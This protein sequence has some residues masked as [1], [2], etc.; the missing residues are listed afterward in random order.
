MK[1][2]L[3]LLLITAAINGYA[4][5]NNTSSKPNI[6]LILAD[7]LGY[8]DI[9]A[10]GSE[11]KTPNLDRL[12]T[13]GLR[14]KEF[15]N[16]SICAP[17]RASLLTGQYQHK[18]G[19]GYFANDLGSPAYQGYL[20]KESLTLAEV[21][22]GAGYTTLMAGK[23]HVSGKGQSL[24][25]QRG[26]DHSLLS[27]NGSYFDQGD[28]NGGP[29]RPY[30]EDGKPY[31]LEAG[32]YY[33]TDVIT[34]H[35]V[36]YLNEQGK[37]KKPFFLYLAYTAPHWPLQALPEDIAKYKGRYDKGWD[38]LR[39]ERFAKQKELGIVD[40]DAVLSAKD[41]DIYDWSRLSYDQ[42]SQWTAKMEVFA[43]MVDR[44]DQG[45][46]Q[47]LDKLKQTGQDKN[48]LVIFIS[49]NGAPAEDLVKWHNGATRNTGP[50]GTIGSYESQGKNWSYASNTPFLAF[51]DYV[52][53]GGISSPFIAWYPSKIKPGTISKGTGHLIDLAPT[54]YEL[55]G[56][57]YPKK[58]KDIVPNALPGKSLL[59]VLYGQDN[60]VKRGEPLFWER[61]GNR[62]V[63][64]GKWKLESHYPSYT[65][66]LYDVESDRGETRDIARFNHDVVSRLSIAYFQWAKKVGS[67]DFSTIEDREPQTMK[68][69]RKSKVQ[70]V[71]APGG[72]GLQ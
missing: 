71:I 44:M 7:D 70:D 39:K 67:V 69:Y 40:K 66:E 64:D 43:A 48:T 30:F 6:I 31:P 19:V 50:V 38:D 51:K 52:Y 36:K 8:S 45:I 46:G 24:P 2:I 68:D 15:Y 37:D 10:Y 60:E 20:N 21:L 28:Y 27:E 42:R 32:K 26:F 49:D 16:N 63:R 65:W 9:G 18:A 54:F 22:K 59:P 23:W 62:A 41:A 5:T 3:T 29:K 4:Q 47:V 72:P 58:Y 11:I 57:S 33:Q 61:A 55:A 1:K 13:E 53:E 35:A 12:A 34:E 14:L 56:A 17:T 25:W